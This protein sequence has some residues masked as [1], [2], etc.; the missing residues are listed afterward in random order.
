MPRPG[1][2]LR[3]AEPELP[4]EAYAA[5]PG[6]YRND[7]PWNPIRVLAGRGVGTE[8]PYESPEQG[9]DTRLIPLADGSFAV[10]AERDPRR[11]RFEGVTA[12][13]KAPVM[14]LNNGRWYRSFE[15]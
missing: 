2:G 5:Y 13:G 3:G 1:H 10:G 12:D 11:V 9:S 15:R 6:F 4:P 7:S 8:W 14:V